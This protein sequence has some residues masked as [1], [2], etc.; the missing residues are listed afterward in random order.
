MSKG[1]SLELYFVDGNPDGMQ[2]AEL[3]GWTGDVLLTPRTKIIQALQ[4]NESSHTGVYVLL[5]E[6]E[7]GP[8]AY[9]G[10]SEDIGNRLREHAKTKDWWELAVLISSAANNLHKAHVKYLESRLV[11]IA[12]TVG[13]IKLEN[14]NKP[15]RSS[16]SE[17]A[18]AN[19]EEFL[20]NLMIVLPALRIDVFLDKTADIKPAII[21]SSQI[22]NAPTFEI[23]SQK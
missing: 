2:T 8:L 16:L 5:G 7:N 19:M 9:V 6:N 15:T 12:L 13:K 10:E 4:R 11:E 22:E 1:R 14:G 3:F 23:D 21:K 18:T 20:D 17:A